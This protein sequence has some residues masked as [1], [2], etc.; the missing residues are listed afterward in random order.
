MACPGYFNDFGVVGRLFKNVDGP[1]CQISR[2]PGLEL[3]CLVRMVPMDLKFVV[4]AFALPSGVF[5][6]QLDTPITL[7]YCDASRLLVKS[8]GYSFVPQS[9]AGEPIPKKIY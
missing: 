4:N 2:S 5:F 3:V 8:S 7:S 6:L 9:E 1:A